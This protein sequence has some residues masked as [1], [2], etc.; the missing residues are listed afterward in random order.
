M[1]LRSLLSLVA[2]L[3]VLEQP[4]GMVV[5]R[6]GA[7]QVVA[8]VGSTQAPTVDKEVLAVLSQW[9][10]VAVVRLAQVVLIPQQVQ[11]ERLLVVLVTWPVQ[12]VVEVV[13]ALEL[14]LVVTVVMVVQAAAAVAVVLPLPGLVALAAQVVVAGHG[15][16]AGK[17]R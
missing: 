3:V 7:V 5:V 13:V 6:C 15:S 10:P 17:E 9:L 11:P 8:V 14:M 1:L 16:Q 12:V 4:Q 2:V